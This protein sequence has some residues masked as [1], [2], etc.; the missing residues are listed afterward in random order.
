M[1]AR[2]LITLVLIILTASVPFVAGQETYTPLELSFII[3]PDGYVA[4]DYSAD[5]DPTKAR[6]DVDLFGSLYQDMLID[7]QDGLPLDYAFY[8][9]GA[10][11]DTLGAALVFISYATTDLTSKSG[12][13]WSFMVTTPI[14]SAILLPVGSTIVSLSAV[15]TAMSDLD[16]NILLTMPPG[17][18]EVSY[19]IGVGTREHALAVI[20][21]AETAIE[22]VKA[23]GV[24]TAEA[25]DLLQEARDAFASELYAEAE[26]LADQAKLSAQSTEIAAASAQEAIDMATGSIGAAESAGRTLGLDEARD[27]LGQAEDA[28]DTGDY[29]GAKSLANQ[30]EATAAAAERPGAGGIPFTWIMALG[31]LLIA[32]LAAFFLRG[33]GRPK[34]VVSRA[35]IDLDA[36]F[37]A[38]QHLRLDDKEVI[39]YLA[40]LGGEAFAAEIRDRFDVPRTSLWRMIR[41]LEGEG[42]VDVQNIGGQSLVRISDKYLA[43]GASR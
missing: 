15:P 42:V 17:I 29:P 7:D 26:Q 1:K 32:A 43:G 3:Y 27:L 9:G 18:T 31:G 22:A 30:A 40:E 25:D 21:D 33:R 39:R 4:V 11:I 12:Q 6:V 8:D 37:G 20:K 34:D 13:I 38:H 41:R 19:T 28:Y 14:D 35:Q 36:L 16:G 24:V 5:V 10:S 23:G 2:S